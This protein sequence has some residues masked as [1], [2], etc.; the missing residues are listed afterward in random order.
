MTHAG[1]PVHLAKHVLEMDR[2]NIL[3][4]VFKKI[5]ENSIIIKVVDIANFEG[6]II[7]EVFGLINRKKHRLLL[8]VNK[9][10]AMPK[11]FDITAA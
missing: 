11:G 5:H 1:V 8:V 6:S 4:K 7:E 3:D 2:K 10:D 9:I